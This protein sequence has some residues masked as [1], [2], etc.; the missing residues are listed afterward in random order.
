LRNCASLR[1]KRPPV[2]SVSYHWSCHFPSIRSP[3]SVPCL[4]AATTV[5]PMMYVRLAGHRLQGAVQGH[6][7]TDAG[8]VLAGIELAALDDRCGVGANGVFLQHG[9]RALVEGSHLQGYRLGNALDGQVA[10]DADG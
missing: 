7:V 10:L 1:T 4:L 2:L 8:C 6:F 9:V 5:A 3:M